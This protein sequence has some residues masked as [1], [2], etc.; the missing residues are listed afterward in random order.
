MSRAGTPNYDNLVK[1]A[2]Q[3]SQ[4]FETQP[5]A[6]AEV[7]IAE[8]IRKFWDPRMRAHIA[9]YVQAGGQGLREPAL[10]AVALLSPPPA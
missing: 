3:I 9:T 1:M 4:F 6:A 8:H 10:R 5:G 7:G 2:N